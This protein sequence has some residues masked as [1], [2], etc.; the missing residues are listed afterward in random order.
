VSYHAKITS[1]GQITLPAELRAQMGL[2]EGD[3]IEF[4]RDHLGRV[5]MRPRRSGVDDVLSALPP[6]RAVREY[7][8]DDD[9]IAAAVLAKDARSRRRKRQPKK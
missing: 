5:S 2:D 4:Y 9:A 7:A 1:K 8:T 6:R 3:T